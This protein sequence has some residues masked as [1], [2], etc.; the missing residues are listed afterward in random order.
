VTAPTLAR[1]GGGSTAGL[2]VRFGLMIFAIAGMNIGY[3]AILPFLPE[4][5][6][7]LHLTPALLTVFLLAYPAAKALTQWFLG[8]RLTDRWGAAAT[9]AVALTCGAAGMGII[10]VAT[11]SGLA[12]AGRLVW[13]LGTGLGIPAVYRATGQLA[14]RYDVPVARLRAGLGAGAVLTLALGPLVAGVVQAFAGFRMVLVFGALLSLLGAVAAGFALRLP[15]EPPAASAAD[16][17]VGR[18]GA[19]ARSF[20][21]PL[22]VFSG[23][24]LMLNLLFAAA[25]PLIPL[26]IA[27][28]QHDSTGRAALVLG[29][30]L[31][32]WV[33]ATLLSGRGS[34]RL[35]TPAAGLVSLVLLA[36][37]CI[38]LA[39]VDVLPVGLVA[40]AVFMLAQGH[41]YLVAR[42]GID[43]HT[44]ASGVVWG[45]F[46]A[47]ADI[48]F[49]LGPPVA[50]AA[51]TQVGELA[52]PVLGGGT[53]I[54]T[55]VFAAG[56]SALLRSSA[57]GQPP[58]AEGDKVVGSAVAP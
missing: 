3:T 23:Y 35:R 10:A 48:G 18:E 42:T 49:L 56:S 52:F 8:G 57:R 58:T 29:V 16:G 31:G 13:G 46:N 4:M 6:R 5:Q 33:I 20:V 45:R 51:Y 53:L 40:I 15:A 22:V 24:E 2:R 28:H 11:E 9:A 14:E 30:G 37:S 12:N 50:V 39:Q 25:E 34:D 1:R 54:A 43:T 47:I 19:L 36:V 44:D 55:A 26:Y 32:V 7:E 17:A 27:G 21:L 41:G 38:G